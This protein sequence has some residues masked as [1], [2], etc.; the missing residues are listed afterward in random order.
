MKLIHYGNNKYDSGLFLPIE[1]LL[2]R[3]KPK[4]GLWTSPI[5]SNYGWK[6][7]TIDNAFMEHPLYF[8]LELKDSAKILRIDSIEDLKELTW[9]DTEYLPYIDFE[10][11]DYDA[12]W[13]T[14]SGLWS[15]TSYDIGRDL[16]GWDVETVLILNKEVI[17]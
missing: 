14:E 2:L 4:G 5:N 11:L 10:A 12:I 3:N 17:R 6:E 15:C 9:I 13:L 1:N 7:W 16:Y 8:E